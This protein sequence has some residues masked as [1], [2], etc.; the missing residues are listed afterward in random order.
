MTTRESI[1]ALLRSEQT[2]RALKFAVPVGTF[3]LGVVAQYLLE[4]Y[5]ADGKADHLPLAFLTFTVGLL[6]IAVGV[7][8]HSSA[9][10]LRLVSST[11]NER[12]DGLSLLLGSVRDATGLTAEYVDDGSTG[13]SYVRAAELIS[14]AKDTIT[15]VDYW[16]PF[17]DYQSDDGATSDAT[18]SARSDFYTAIEEAVQQHRKGNHLFHRRVVQIPP[19]RLN[20]PIPFAVDPPFEEYLGRIA[21][22]QEEAP[23]CCRLRVSPAQIR[24]HFIM[25]DERFIVLPIL[26]TD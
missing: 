5:L 24:F 1:K 9:V 17:D 12:A 19:S 7:Q 3:V 18:S 14:Q 10:D 13:A 6:V 2:A 15:I 20:Q 22:I 26:R 23:R 4:G 25:I 16:E 8:S 21:E 11:V